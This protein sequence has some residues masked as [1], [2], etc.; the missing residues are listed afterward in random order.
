MGTNVAYNDESD[1]DPDHLRRRRRCSRADIHATLAWRPECSN[2]ERFWRCRTVAISRCTSATRTHMGLRQQLLDIF[3]DAVDDIR[4]IAPE[5]GGAFGAKGGL[6]PEYV[7]TVHAAL[8][9]GQ[10]VKFIE[11]RS[12][13]LTVTWHGRGQ[14][15]RVAVGVKNDG[16]LVGLRVEVDADFGAGIDSQRWSV[17]LM[18]LML[19]GAYR[20]PKIEWTVRGVLTH[21]AP[22]GVFR[23]A[24]RPQAAYLVERIIDEIARELGLDPAVVRAQQLRASRRVPLCHGHRINLRLGQLRGGSAHRPRNRVVRRASDENKPLQPTMAMADSSA[25]ASQVTWN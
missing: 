6:Y 17:L 13:N 8:A 19:S 24:G 18:R 21:T 14:T 25:S 20:I 3:G 10:P 2:H 12:E 16:T 4:V 9:T 1:H 5:V 23:G 7:L 15:Q 11:T 22:M